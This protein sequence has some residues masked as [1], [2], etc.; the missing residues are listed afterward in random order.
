MLCRVG[1]STKKGVVYACE[2][3]GELREVRI[4]SW[5]RGWKKTKENVVEKKRKRGGK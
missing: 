4:D 3:D 1:T 2:A 5:H